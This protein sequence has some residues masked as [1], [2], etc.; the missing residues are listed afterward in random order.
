MAKNVEE[1]ALELTEKFSEKFSESTHFKTYCEI[2]AYL[3]S[4]DHCKDALRILEHALLTQA[5]IRIPLIAHKIKTELGEEFEHQ[6]LFK[7]F[8]GIRKKRWLD[9]N[10]SEGVENYRKYEKEFFTKLLS[11]TLTKWESQNGFAII[12]GDSADILF[13]NPTRLFNE[14]LASG[15]PFKDIGAGPMH[16]EYSHRIQW[17][18]AGVGLKIDQIGSLYMD[19]KRWITRDK[20]EGLDKSTAIKRYLWECLLDRDG[21]PTNAASVAFGADDKLDF[22]APSN[23]NLYLTSEEAGEIYP[24]LGLCVADR[25]LK[26]QAEAKDSSRIDTSYV[27]KIARNNARVQIVHNA[28]LGVLVHGEATESNA[29]YYNVAQS[30]LFIRRKGTVVDVNWQAWPA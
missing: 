21:I 30:G 28:R 20:L 2:G 29:K 10:K 13:G 23:L 26:R 8:L 27:Y 12:E 15:R 17:Y 4:L 6:A 7:F 24:L 11:S 22:R 9:S 1:V 19:I 3:S 25:Y 5:L 16:G 14:Q 18:L